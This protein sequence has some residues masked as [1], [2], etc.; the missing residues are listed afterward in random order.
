MT[1]PQLALLKS[2]RTRAKRARH[3]ATVARA[4]AAKTGNASTR[5]FLLQ[6]AERD[7][8]IARAAEERAN[9]H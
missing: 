3:N 7:E 2:W 4:A 6:A 5:Q 1:D 9:A 8:A